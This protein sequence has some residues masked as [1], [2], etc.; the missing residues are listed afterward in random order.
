MQLYGGLYFKGF[1]IESAQD[2]ETIAQEID[3]HLCDKHP[4][5]CSTRTWYTKYTCD[6]AK[7]DI[8]QSLVPKGMHNED[9]Y[10]GYIP[11]TIMFYSLEPAT[12]GGETLVADCRKV[13]RDLPDNLKKKLSGKIMINKLIMHDDVFLVNSRIP[14]DFEMIKELGESHNSQ[15]TLRLSENLAQF[16]FEIPAV[17]KCDFSN[18]PIWFNL[19][20]I[21]HYFSYNVYIDTWF[22]YKRK[23]GFLNKTKAIRIVCLT[24]L[25]DLKYLVK[26]FMNRDRENPE[27]LS[28]I[29]NYYVSDGTKIS[30]LD[31]IQI[32][33]A[34][35]KNTA[36][37]PLEKGDMVALDNRLTSHGRMPFKGRRVVLASIGSLTTVENFTASG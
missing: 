31:R 3:P 24:F 7:P 28:E 33:L 5:N 32:N 4:F 36:I 6:V 29:G 16:S 21:A 22:A 23:K 1:N 10:V 20:H 27:F 30:L 2:F 37:I 17:I 9:S 12:Q 35:W 26:S 25:S 8:E 14:K 13:Y 15:E 11:K 18:D 34:I 19:L